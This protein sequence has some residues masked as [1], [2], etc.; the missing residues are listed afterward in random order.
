MPEIQQIRIGVVNVHSEF[1]KQQKK[2][3]QTNEINHDIHP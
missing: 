2:Q 1:I 3:T